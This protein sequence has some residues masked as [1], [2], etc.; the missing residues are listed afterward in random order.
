MPSSPPLLFLLLAAQHLVVIAPTSLTSFFVSPTGSDAAEGTSTAPWRTLAHAQAQARKARQQQHQ[1]HPVSVSLLGGDFR[2]NQT[3]VFD[4]ADSGITWHAAPGVVPRVTASTS[5]PWSAF[6]PVSMRESRLSTAARAHVRVAK[7]TDVA[8]GLV[9]SA[10]GSGVAG[11]DFRNTD[12]LQIFAGR[13]RDPLTLARYPNVGA[14]VEG[15]AFVGYAT[16]SAGYPVTA[17][18][19][20]QP[21]P[22]S[23]SSS[24]LF[25]ER[26]ACPLRFGLCPAACSP[27]ANAIS[28]AGATGASGMPKERPARWAATGGAPQL[29]VHGAWRYEWADQMMS[30]TTTNLT[31]STFVFDHAR[32]SALRY[33]PPQEGAPYYVLDLLQELDAPGEWWLD[34]ATGELFI[35]PPTEYSTCSPPEAC[36]PLE[37]SHPLPFPADARTSANAQLLERAGPI[38]LYRFYLYL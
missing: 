30:V 35:Y 13:G 15:S 12:R 4:A 26:C 14:A 18:D 33:W 24:V 21:D 3:L 9:H 11:W 27:K 1:H 37:I 25:K 31:N 23:N 10:L 29:A 5:V 28:F 32:C 34:R 6:K 20:A 36:L 17:G 16:A 22:L 19:T 38:L 7:L 8:P 2:V